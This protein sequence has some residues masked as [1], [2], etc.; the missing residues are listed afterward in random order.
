MKLP[1]SPIA[2]GLLVPFTTIRLKSQ[3]LPS[4][5]PYNLERIIGR[6][7]FEPDFSDYALRK[8]TVFKAQ[9]LC[10]LTTPPT[11]YLWNYR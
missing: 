9:A 6:S 1:N 5:A 2:L 8:R 3:G 4:L 7:G 11:S 10:V